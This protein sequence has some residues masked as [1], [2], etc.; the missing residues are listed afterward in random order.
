[1]KGVESLLASMIGVD[2]NKMQ[3]MMSGFIDNAAYLAKGIDEI[4]AS[5]DA[6]NKRLDDME[7]PPLDLADVALAISD[8]RQENVESHN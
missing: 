7:K 6:I 2:A 3:E 1:M 4:K 8:E 5:I